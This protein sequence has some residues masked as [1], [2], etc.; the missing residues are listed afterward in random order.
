[1]QCMVM[2][3]LCSE[4]STKYKNVPCG[5]NVP[6]LNVKPG[7]TQSNPWALKVSMYV[8]KDLAAAKKVTQRGV[9]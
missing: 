3:V 9:Y 1:M 7:G 2:N 6:C 5:Q 4:N 8:C